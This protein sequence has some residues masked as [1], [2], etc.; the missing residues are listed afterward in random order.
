MM[1][2]IA[3]LPNPQ[4]PEAIGWMVLTLSGAVLILERGLAVI[5]G[6]RRVPAMEAEFLS[7]AD[8][9]RDCSMR[10]LRVASLEARMDRVERKMETDKAE[11]IA[12]G[13]HRAAGIYKSIDAMKNELGRSNAEMPQRIITLLQTTGA[14]K[15]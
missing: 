12:A 4:S 1:T 9:E 14:L 15:K 13:E 3:Q 10:T 6:F 7:K 11:I 5:R 8:H 2:M